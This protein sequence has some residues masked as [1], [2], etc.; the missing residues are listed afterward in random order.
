MSLA[1]IEIEIAG[2][3]RRIQFKIPSLRD[4][5]RVM[6]KPLGEVLA[7]MARLG[8]RDAALGGAPRRRPQADDREGA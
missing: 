3:P 5:E 2:K 7:D 4:L 6:A 8:A 1:Y